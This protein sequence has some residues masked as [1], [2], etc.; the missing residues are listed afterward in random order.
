MIV[1]SLLF[2]LM[3][4]CVKLGAEQFSTSELVLFRG[5]VATL[6]LAGW[7]IWRGASLR[8]KHW[9]VHL[10]RSGAGFVALV[11]YY[12]AISRIPLATAATLS[13]T[14]PLFLA[15]LLAFRKKE[16]HHRHTY[17]ALA[18]GF[19]GV[20]L[21]L[22]PTLAPDQWLGGVMG[23]LAGMA[24]SVAFL[25]VRRLG[26]LGEP[27]W[28][29]VFYFS[30]FSTLACLPWVLAD[31]DFHK[32]DTRG[33]WLILGIGGF[34]AAAQVCMTIA[35]ARGRTLATAIL[36]YTTVVFASLFGILLW[37]ETLP[38][39]AWMGIGLIIAAGIAATLQG[40]SA[41]RKPPEL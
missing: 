39:L 5:L 32:I 17:L 13:Y 38:L 33:A 9:W 7:V 11:A 27:E 10:R 36:V 25:N 20:I 28:R 3:G 30:L 18:A 6:L 12:F 31:A 34:G 1:A 16:S 26:E 40:N 41:R 15:L 21:L 22:Q 4:V 14:S 29:T 23:L 8:T 19:L 37:R 35:Y 24:S 2:A